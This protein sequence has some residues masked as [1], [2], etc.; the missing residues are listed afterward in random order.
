MR[1]IAALVTVFMLA[2]TTAADA[3]ELGLSDPAP[4]AVL[5]RPPKLIRLVFTERL[6]EHSWRLAVTDT[7]GSTVPTGKP[8]FSWHNWNQLIV[9]PL[10]E[11]L[12]SGRYTIAWSTASLEGSHGNGTFNFTLK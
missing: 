5:T 10:D 2:S 3:L 7:H 11:P 1:H 9:V 12:A 4:G 8:F 6:D